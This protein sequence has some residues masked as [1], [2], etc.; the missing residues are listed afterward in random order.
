MYSDQV[1]LR[2]SYLFLISVNVSEQSFFFKSGKFIVLYLGCS[3]M[4]F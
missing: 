1:A 3:C 2:N 4:A